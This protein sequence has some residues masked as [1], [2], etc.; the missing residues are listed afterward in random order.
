MERHID[1]GMDRL[2]TELLT[3][4]G[5]VEK[6]LECAISA[7]R[8]RNSKKIHE[9]YVIE[10]KVNQSHLTVDAQCVEILALQHP[11]ATDLRRIISIIRMNT[12]LERMVDLAVNIAN[13]TEYYLKTE[14]SYP[15]E[16]LVEMADAVQKMVRAVLDA[17]VAGSEWDAQSVLDSEEKVD[18]YKAQIFTD[19][20]S[21]VQ[22][23]PTVLEQGMDIIL[24]ARNLERIAD[25]AT[26]VAEEVIYAV[27][28]KDI[29]HGA[30]KRSK[31]GSKGQGS[32]RRGR[33]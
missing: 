10:E 7:W 23:T 6:A 21:Y 22:K 25:H 26:N 31:H 18:Q 8:D 12:D 30:K 20:L 27:S 14:P 4:A 2:H 19:V 3:M 1:S 15:L 13:N 9:V 29:R 28:G 24:I 32:D 33:T 17:F 16:R 11:F 5:Y